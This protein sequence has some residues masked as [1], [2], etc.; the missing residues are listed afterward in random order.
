V[1]DVIHAE[2][3]ENHQIPINVFHPL[4]VQKLRREVPCDVLVNKGVILVK[5]RV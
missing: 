3:M 1:S 4:V 2:V 5:K